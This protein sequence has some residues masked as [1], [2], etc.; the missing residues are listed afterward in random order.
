MRHKGVPC[1]L[2]KSK[3]IFFTKRGLRR[4]CGIPGHLAI[5]KG[6]LF[7]LKGAGAQ[8]RQKRPPCLQGT[9]KEFFYN[10]RGPGVGAAK[11]AT[12][13]SEEY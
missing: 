5:E 1:F 12:V 3:G 6:E 7:L 2:C 9:T 8:G 4:E 11:G 10:K 13:A